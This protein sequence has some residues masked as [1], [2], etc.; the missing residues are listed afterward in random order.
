MTGILIAPEDLREIKKLYEEVLSNAAYGMFFREGKIIG[1]SIWNSLFRKRTVEDI[2]ENEFIAKT[3]EVLQSRGFIKRLE[4]DFKTSK[5]VVHGS[6]ESTLSG[7]PSCHRLSGV[8]TALVEKKLNKKV[9]CHEIKC[10]T[11]ND[12]ECIFVIM[13]ETTLY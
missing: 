1:Y 7:E 4:A 8:L 3:E 10:M 11:G 9:L 2:P 12:D 13:G 5:I 6:A